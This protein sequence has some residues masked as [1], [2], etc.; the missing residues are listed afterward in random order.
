[1]A[2]DGTEQANY[3][4]IFARRYLIKNTM[5]AVGVDAYEESCIV[6]VLEK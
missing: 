3:L 5:G 4:R 1:M 6:S 2:R